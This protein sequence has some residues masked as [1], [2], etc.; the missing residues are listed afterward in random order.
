MAV[1][2]NLGK[3]GTAEVLLLENGLVEKRFYLEESVSRDLLEQEYFL[4]E[5]I[6]EYCLNHKIDPFVPEPSICDSEGLYYRMSFVSGQ[7]VT[8]IIENH[9]SS[10][11]DLKIIAKQLVEKIKIFAVGSN[12]PYFDCTPDNLLWNHKDKKLNFIDLGRPTEL[13]IEKQ[14]FS[15]LESIDWS[16]NKF[17]MTVVKEFSA[18]SR[19]T[20]LIFLKNTWILLTHLSA[21]TKFADISLN[22]PLKDS[23]RFHHRMWKN[24]SFLSRFYYQLLFLPSYLIVQFIFSKLRNK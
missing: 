7:P 2:K 17:L 15:D 12:F 13:F 6:H 16:I 19:I 20:K 8:Q 21:A 3:G 4:L 23:Y 1:S 18:P 5:K 14:S 11:E 10:S 9:Y 22:L 24:S